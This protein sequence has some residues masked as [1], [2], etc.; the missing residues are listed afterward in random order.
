MTHIACRLTAK[1]RDQLRNPMLSNRVWA[2]FTF[3]FPPSL[4][5]PPYTLTRETLSG[6]ENAETLS[7]TKTRVL[8][9]YRDLYPRT[10]TPEHVLGNEN[11]ETQTRKRDNTVPVYTIPGCAKSSC[12]SGR[13]A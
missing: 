2:T 10:S 12:I 11:T 5:L 8:T 3:T 13:I 6:E 7:E 9:G 4:H 1:N